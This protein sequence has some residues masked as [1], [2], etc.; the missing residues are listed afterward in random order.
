[1]ASKRRRVDQR[2]R[3]GCRRRAGCRW[4]AVGRPSTSRVDQLVDDRARARS[5]GAAWCSAARRCRRRR[6]RCRAAARSRSAL[7]ARRRRRCCRRAPAGAAEARRRRA[8]PTARPIRVE[9]GGRLT[10]GDARRRRPAP[11]R[12]RGR[13][14]RARCS[15]SRAR[16]PR[17]ARAASSASAGQRGQRGLLRRLP[18]HGVAADQGERGVPGPDRDREVERGD[19]AD[20]AERVPGLHQPVARALRGDGQAVELAGQPDREVADV[21]HLL[22]LAERLGADLAG[23]ER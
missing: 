15:P 9:P 22:H 19:D 5:A 10:S 2:A 18:D 23:L 12:P 20:D 11:R 14:A 17:P 3:P 13:R 7:T 4:A 21:D 8:A 1:M 16:R 6:T